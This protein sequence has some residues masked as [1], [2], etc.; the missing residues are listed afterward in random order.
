MSLFSSYWCF[1]KKEVF[2]KENRWSLSFLDIVK[3]INIKGRTA[4]MKVDFS[5]LFYSDSDFGGAAAAWSDVRAAFIFG[6][7]AAHAQAWPVHVTAHS[8]TESLYDKQVNAGNPINCLKLLSLRA[9]YLLLQ[10]SED[11]HS[12][13]SISLLWFLL[14]WLEHKSFRNLKNHGTGLLSYE[15]AKSSENWKGAMLEKMEALQKNESWDL[16]F[17][18]PDKN[19]VGYGWAYKIKYK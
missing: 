4:L 12:Y 1:T 6:F 8:Q 10:I 13:W 11:P 5:L 17:P 18:P 16:V 7:S 14:S 9:P 19:I 2:S 15:K 3:N